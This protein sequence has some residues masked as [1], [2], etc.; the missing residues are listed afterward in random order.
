VITKKPYDH[1]ANT[2]V[3]DLVSGFSSKKRDATLKANYPLLKE[4]PELINHIVADP[5]A[6]IGLTS[7][8]LK[9]L[10]VAAIEKKV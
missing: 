8:V 4:K 1:G 2:E 3:R 10:H 5:S 6:A 9:N 7:A